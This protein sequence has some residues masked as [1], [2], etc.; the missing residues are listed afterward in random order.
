M[1]STSSTPAADARD[2]G[3]EV[4]T[5]F[6][7]GADGGVRVNVKPE[8]LPEHSDP[9]AARWVFGYRVR[10]TNEGPQP[11]TLLRRHWII[12]DG[13]GDRHDVEG[14]GVVGHQPRLE[15]GEV[16][17]YASYCPLETRWGTM[18][19]EF[20]MVPNGGES[21]AARVARFYLVAPEADASA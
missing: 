7:P 13:D 21:F 20:H 5:P 16:F 19:G 2:L 3:S 1:R 14:D 6:T 11:V 17:E 15:P 12:V 8:F 9:S 18:E 10:I 4:V